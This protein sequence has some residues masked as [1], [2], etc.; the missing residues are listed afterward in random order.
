M[1]SKQK[2]IIEALRACLKRNNITQAQLAVKLGISQPSIN[3]YLTGRRFPKI[4]TLSRIADVLG[5]TINEL[6]PFPGEVD[7]Y[8]KLSLNLEALP[9]N[10]YLPQIK[11][12]IFCTLSDLRIEGISLKQKAMI[13]NQICENLDKLK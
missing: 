3:Q 5:I 6:I 11:N 7:N 4:E 8:A 10:E 1:D 13:Y 9:L 2:I 12:N